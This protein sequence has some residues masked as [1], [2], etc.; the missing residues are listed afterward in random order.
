MGL[1]LFSVVNHRLSAA[2][3]RPR[4]GHHVTIYRSSSSTYLQLGIGPGDTDS[5]PD[6]VD[7]AC[8][9]EISGRI[10]R[11]KLGHPILNKVI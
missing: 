7:D 1:V 11:Q 10:G 8:Y 6:P 3:S 2:R 5:R 4:L 9:N